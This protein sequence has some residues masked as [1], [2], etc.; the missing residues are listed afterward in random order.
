M[1][2]GI[3]DQHLIFRLKWGSQGKEKCFFWVR[4]PSLPQGLDEQVPQKPEGLDLPLQLVVL[5][6]KGSLIYCKQ[7]IL[8]KE[9]FFIWF[10][11][12]FVSQ[13]PDLKEI[14]LIGFYQS[15]EN[16]SKFIT[17]AQQEFNIPIR[18]YAINSCTLESHYYININVATFLRI[19]LQICYWL[20]ILSIV[21]II[22]ADGIIDLHVN[23]YFTPYL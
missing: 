8:L 11:I 21:K 1:G 16:L 20:E 12:W 2:P 15:S 23:D 17:N 22:K 5:K 9:L 6:A 14:I 7:R 3:S 4:A 10:S 18:Y 19:W 13:I